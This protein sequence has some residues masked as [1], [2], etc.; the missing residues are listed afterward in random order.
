MIKKPY[1]FAS[2]NFLRYFRDASGADISAAALAVTL[3]PTSLPFEITGFFT[4]RYGEIVQR[5]V[6]MLILQDTNIAALNIEAADPNGVYSP[7]FELSGNTDST[8]LVKLAAPVNTSS[9]RITI[10]A[11]GNP[12]EVSAGRIGLH[13]FVLDT[14]ALTDSNFKTQ[15]NA[16][17]FRTLSGRYIHYSD[18][19]KWEAKM[20]LQDLPQQ[21]FNLLAAQT[22]DTAEM[23]LVPFEDF[24][25]AAIYECGIHP[26]LD[27]SVNRKTG[28]YE[29]TL[30]AKEL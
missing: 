22:A 29:L 9:V 2:E 26:E 17:S 30:E 24:D 20:K 6:D 10:P 27:Y 11:E 12:D 15:A 23:T 7:L 3:D 25:A 1:L 19:K 13:R 21:Q 8:V 28:L 4:D 5:D 16:G 14:W 18:Y